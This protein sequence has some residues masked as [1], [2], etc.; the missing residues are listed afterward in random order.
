MKSFFLNHRGKF[1]LTAFLTL[2]SLGIY[3]RRKWEK[4]HPVQEYDIP[5]KDTIVFFASGNPMKKCVH[6]VLN[7]NASYQDLKNSGF[8]WDGVKVEKDSLGRSKMICHNLN[9]ENETHVL[10]FEKDRNDDSR[11]FAIDT[12]ACKNDCEISLS[13]KE[14]DCMLN[15]ER[16]KSKQK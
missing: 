1:F 13:F 10:V 6:L 14:T 9:G 3:E 8:C 5:Q 2:L 4:L 7:E 16:K 12:H 15:K 11:I